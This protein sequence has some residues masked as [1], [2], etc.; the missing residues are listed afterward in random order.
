MND[1]HKDDNTITAVVKY[2][3]SLLDQRKEII[4]RLHCNGSKYF[5]KLMM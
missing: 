2:S 5:F 4:L 3:I 1:P